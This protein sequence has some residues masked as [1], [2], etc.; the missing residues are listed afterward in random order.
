MFFLIFFII[1]IS[2]EVSRPAASLVTLS[3]TEMIYQVRTFPKL[4]FLFFHTSVCPQQSMNLRACCNDVFIIIQYHKQY[5]IKLLK[6]CGR[7]TQIC[8]F[9]TMNLGTSASSPYCHSTRGK[10]SRGIAPS[11]TTRVFGEYFLKI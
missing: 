8:V 4:C 9:N 10:V 1:I 2:Y 6:H 3:A 11:N 5:L 7:M